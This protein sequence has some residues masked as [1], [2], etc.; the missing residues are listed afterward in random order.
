TQLKTA[1]RRSL[2]A[3]FCLRFDRQEANWWLHTFARGSH[4]DVDAF[5]FGDQSLFVSRAD[6]R[7]TGGYDEGL[8]LLE[9]HEMVRRLRRHCGGFQLLPADVTTSA[10]RYLQYGVVYTQSVFVLIFCLYYLWV[11]QRLLLRLYATA[12]R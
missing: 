1:A 12:F 10:R 2:P 9:G 7:A 5:R 3:S 6:F 8:A 11:P 4:W